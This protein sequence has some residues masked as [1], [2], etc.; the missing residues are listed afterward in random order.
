MKMERNIY[1]NNHITTAPMIKAAAICITL[2]YRKRLLLIVRL[3]ANFTSHI[4]LG[5]T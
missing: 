3:A 1:I 5:E 4:L 2:R